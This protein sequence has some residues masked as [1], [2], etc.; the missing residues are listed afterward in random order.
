MPI[1]EE[2]WATIMARGQNDAEIAALVSELKMV[3][4]Q[5][6]RAESERDEA[7]DAMQVFRTLV[8]S[9][10]K[11]IAAAKE[12]AKRDLDEEIAAARSNADAWEREAEKNAALSAR[13][14]EVEAAL[15]GAFFVGEI[16]FKSCVL[17]ACVHDKI[18]RVL[19]YTP[20]LGEPPRE[21]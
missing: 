4:N 13:V 20:K 2:E 6:A 14:R 19:G 10:N 17:A 1:D 15:H 7:R 16:Y 9:Q 11:T 12:G 5:L 18:V 8:A 3:R 21:T